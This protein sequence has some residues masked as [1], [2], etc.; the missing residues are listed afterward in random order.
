MLFVIKIN[1]V[2]DAFLIKFKHA[3]NLVL[4]KV[5]LDLIFEAIVISLV[6]AVESDL[7]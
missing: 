3:V 5:I 7:K 6:C 2:V 1:Q 4:V